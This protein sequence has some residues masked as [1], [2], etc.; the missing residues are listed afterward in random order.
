MKKFT[1]LAVVAAFV[2]VAGNAMALPLNDNRPFSGFEG[3]ETSLQQILDTAT[4]DSIDAV[5]DQSNVA[6]W[7]P[8]YDGDVDS[9]LISAVRG[10]S[11]SL[12]IY[13]YS[14]GMEYDFPFGELTGAFKISNSGGLYIQGW[15]PSN[16]IQY[17]LVD[18]SFGDSFG[19]YWHNTK[20]D[21][22]FYTEDSRNGGDIQALAYNVDAGIT[23][24]INEFSYTST[25]DD[26]ILA[27]EDIAFGSSDK[28]FNDAVFYIEDLSA[29]VPEPGTVLLLGAGL[30]GL[31]GLRKRIKK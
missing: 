3:T 16:L 4:G 26:W 2:L 31:V 23:T 24:T 11:G 30:L 27:F 12:G 28:D 8:S 25:G 5:G 17:T 13:S 6:I 10:D 9:Y 19:F 29:A 22:K 14:T 20:K 1:V 21:T 15:D 18:A 7:T